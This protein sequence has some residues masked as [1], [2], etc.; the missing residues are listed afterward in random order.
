MKRPGVVFL[1]MA[2]ILEAGA[3]NYQVT[4]AGAGA[5]STVDSVKVENLSQCTSLNMTGTDTLVLSGTVGLEETGYPPAEGMVVYPNPSPGDFNIVME[6]AN[7]GASRVVLFDFTGNVILQQDEILQA[8]HHLFQMKDV[9]HG[10]YLLRIESGNQ[11]YQ[12][13][14]VSRGSETGRPGVKHLVSMTESDSQPDLFSNK[15]LPG[16]RSSGT[17]VIMQFNNGDTLKMTARSGNYRTVKMLFPTQGQAV[18]FTFVPC[19]DAD[20]NHYAV[21][22]VGSQ[23]WMQE[24]LKTTRYRDGSVIQNVTDSAAWA[25]LLSGAWCDYH[26]LPAEGMYYGHFYNFYAVDDSRNLCPAGWHV[27]TH[28][29]W[30]T[31]EKLLDNTVDT[32]ALGGCGTLIGRILKEG[33]NTRWQYM[34]TTYGFNSAGFTALCTNYRTATGAWSLAPGNNHDD[35]FWT[36]S[37][38][39]ASSAWFRSLRWCYGDIYTLFPMKK[40]GYSVR[41]IRN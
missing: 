20:S 3:Q 18:T 6:T 24:N 14:V 23:L 8:G 22:Q 39:N 32:T 16:N 21:V 9:R 25:N 19:T 27:P 17:K 5:S 41:C 33:C 2:I 34:D 10:I 30:N 28:S 11:T 26:N 35:G 40:S 4:F 7:T 1:I 13:K 31:M 12:A 38:Y 37:A 36:A 15:H 29:E